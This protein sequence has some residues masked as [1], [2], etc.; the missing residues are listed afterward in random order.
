MKTATQLLHTLA[1]TTGELLELVADRIG[2]LLDQL[3]QARPQP[4]PPRPDDTAETEPGGT[5]GA[6][7][8]PQT[9]PANATGKK[10]EPTEVKKALI[11]VARRDKNIA[12]RILEHH[13]ATK[14]DDLPESA[15]PQIMKEI[16][17]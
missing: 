1:S 3:G 2:P 8:P 16:A 10:Y 6:T 14:F 12:K 7:T 9:Q 5:G 17:A 11:E 15:Y 13:H 4:H